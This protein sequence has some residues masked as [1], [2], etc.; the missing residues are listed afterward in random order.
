MA[1]PDAKVTF[2]AGFKN[3]V[4]LLFIPS[5]CLLIFFSCVPAQTKKKKHPRWN[6]QKHQA[7]VIEYAK[8]YLVSEIEPNVPQMMFADWFQ[9][10]VGQVAKVEWDINDC[11]EQTGT[12]ADRGRDFPMC[13]E[14][15]SVKAGFIYI[16]VTI[17]FGTFKRGIMKIKP[18]VRSITVGEE[19][20]GNWIDKLSDLPEYLVGSEKKSEYPNPTGGVFRVSGKQPAGFENIDELLIRTM[21]YDGKNKNIYVES[22]GGIEIGQIYYEI[23][24]IILENEN[25]YLE[26]KKIN[27]V[28]FKFL[29]KLA[30]L[31]FNSDGSMLG[32][33]ALRGHLTKL[34]NGQKAAETDL[35]FDFVLN[36]PCKGCGQPPNQKLLVPDQI[37]K[38]SEIKKLKPATGVFTTQGFVVHTYVCPP[39]PPNTLCKPCMG[40]HLVISEENRLWKDYS[41]MDNQNL[42]I[43]TKDSK[44]FMKGEKYDFK[45]QITD[46]K[47]TGEPLNDVQLISYKIRKKS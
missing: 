45:I 7:E 34:I 41:L 44:Q 15:K 5:I 23:G 18:I 35:V 12:S 1:S 25:L 31:K 8:K 11:G 27:D 17:Q 42:I 16:S 6:W 32:E 47:S 39:C 14:A 21:D 40:N 2:M 24:G 36:S 4:R 9:Q 43:F 26:T 33:K 19:I 22:K 30:K 28:S 37:L 20:G 29:G 13:V 3:I 38:I 10:T 46:R